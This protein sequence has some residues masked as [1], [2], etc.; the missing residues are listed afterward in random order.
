MTHSEKN[1]PGKN[2][3]V[4]DCVYI[5]PDVQIYAGHVGLLIAIEPGTKFCLGCDYKLYF[6]HLSY[7]VWCAEDNLERV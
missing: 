4:G 2:F 5:K 6:C 7:N 1:F 3:K